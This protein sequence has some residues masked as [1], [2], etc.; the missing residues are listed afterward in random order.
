[1][2]RRLVFLCSFC[3]AGPPSPAHHASFFWLSD[4]R[5]INKGHCRSPG[6][7]PRSPPPEPAE[8]SPGVQGDLDTHPP[9]LPARLSWGC[10][11][12]RQG[13]IAPAGSLGMHLQGCSWRGAPGGLHLAGCTKRARSGTQ[14]PA[15]APRPS[16]GTNPWPGLRA[17]GVGQRGQGPRPQGCS[18]GEEGDRCSPEQPCVESGAAEGLQVGVRVGRPLRAPLGRRIKVYHLNY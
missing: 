10:T 13:C 14:C 7:S 17:A 2:F 3:S 6:A 18:A 4:H 9:M 8:P 12:S 16:V 5:K 15:G 11:S 1:M